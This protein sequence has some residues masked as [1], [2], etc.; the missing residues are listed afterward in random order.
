MSFCYLSLS[1]FPHSFYVFISSLSLSCCFKC[2]FHSLV[3]HFLFHTLEQI[4]VHLSS[5]LP[6]LFKALCALSY[7]V[8]LVLQGIILL[9]AIKSWQYL[10]LIIYSFCMA[11]FFWWVFHCHLFPPLFFV[12]YFF[13]CLI[14]LSN[15]STWHKT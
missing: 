10:L 13:L 3:V 6:Y 9:S 7:W 1:C 14:Y 15:Q 8:C 11:S 4:L 2:G 5:V 12:D